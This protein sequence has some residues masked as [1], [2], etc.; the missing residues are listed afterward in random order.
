[1]QL[2]ADVQYE[3]G[4]LKLF[5]N[6]HKNTYADLIFNKVEGLEISQNNSQENTCTRVLLLIKLHA[7]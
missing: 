7:K 1:M 6:L 3:I 5:Q 2:F 4:F